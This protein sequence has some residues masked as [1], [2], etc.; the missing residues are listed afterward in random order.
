MT[1]YKH[2]HHEV[3]RLDDPYSSHRLWDKKGFS[4]EE[5]ADWIKRGGATIMVRVNS[6]HQNLNFNINWITYTK[7]QAVH[8]RHKINLEDL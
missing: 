5:Q 7:K 4:Y 3:E 6:F 2:R 8:R 1:D